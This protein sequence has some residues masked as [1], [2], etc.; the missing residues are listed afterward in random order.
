VA[1][2]AKRR[3]YTLQRVAHAEAAMSEL[4][5]A[6]AEI[7]AIRAQVA[8]ETQFRGYGPRSTALSG[9]LALGVAAGQALWQRTHGSGPEVFLLIWV[10]T[11]IAAAAISVWETVYRTRRVHVGFS[12][13]MF[14]VAIEQFLPAVVVG[15]MLTV[16]LDRLAPQE[17]WML[18]GLW[19][20]AFSLGVF[21]SC[22]FLPRPMFAV[23]LWYLVSGLACLAI[24][25]GPH[26][27]SPWAMGIPFG[28]GQL[29]VAGVL[30]YG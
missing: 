29:L 5:Q 2:A 18:P 21:S 14:Q 7:N 28:I 8:R 25:A 12:R 13:E 24:A 15:L 27:L 3:A 6:L 10:A 9:L 19:Q 20:L 1:C 23:G 11:A 4:R 16:V 30:R 17:V 22:R 26:E